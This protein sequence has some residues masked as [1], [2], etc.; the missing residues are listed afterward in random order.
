MK[1]EEGQK[2][3]VNHDFT[4]HSLDRTER[5]RLL[6]VFLY[7]NDV[8]ETNF[9]ELQGR[10]VVF[11]WN[12]SSCCTHSK[13]CY[14]TVSSSR[15]RYELVLLV[16]QRKGQQPLNGLS[17]QTMQD[18]K[19]ATAFLPWTTSS[20]RLRRF[21]SLPLLQSHTRDKSTPCVLGNIRE[22]RK[23]GVEKVWMV[24]LELPRCMEMTYAEAPTSGF[25]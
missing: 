17:T 12:V 9:P 16:K 22:M 5:H 1:Y 23:R 18:M 25:F 7:L 20:V 3:G 13:I 11:G 8:Q 4:H 21:C 24:L 10:K 6:T 2:Y 19:N 15:P 14:V